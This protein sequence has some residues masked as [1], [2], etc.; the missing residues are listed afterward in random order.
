MLVASNDDERRYIE[1]LSLASYGMIHMSI[2]PSYNLG[3]VICGPLQGRWE[4]VPRAVLG[5][6]SG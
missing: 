6:A 1:K 3:L 2:M 5:A 4:H